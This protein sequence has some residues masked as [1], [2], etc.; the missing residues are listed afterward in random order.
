MPGFEHGFQ[1]GVNAV[2]TALIVGVIVGLLAP[3]LVEA[4]LLPPGLFSGLIVLS[5]FTAIMTVDA[6][7]YWPYAYLGGFVIGVFL[8]LPVLSQTEFIG[9]TDWLLYGGTAV[10]AVALRLKIHSSGF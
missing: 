4:G 9:L 3:R 7:R 1:R 8:A 5:I 6:S 2:V 10:G